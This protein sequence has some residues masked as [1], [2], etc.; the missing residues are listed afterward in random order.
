MLTETFEQPQ[1]FTSGATVTGKVILNGSTVTSV[2]VS[3]IQPPTDLNTTQVLTYTGK[4]WAPNVLINILTGIRAPFKFI[5]VNNLPVLCIR[6]YLNDP[7]LVSEFNDVRLFVHS[8]SSEF[9]NPNLK[10][11]L[12]T[13]AINS[14]QEPVFVRGTLS[15]GKIQI[16]TTTSTLLTADIVLFEL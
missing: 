14:N 1:L 5:N 6:A 8:L 13:N 11:S 3:C 16:F 9:Y 10:Y 4:T 12:N 2:P 15:Q 7:I